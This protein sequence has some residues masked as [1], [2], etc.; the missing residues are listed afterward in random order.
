MVGS[1]LDYIFVRL[2]KTIYK[3]CNILNFVLNE[4]R[5]LFL[6]HFDFEKPE[7]FHNYDST[8]V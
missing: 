2:I 3:S 7:I 6:S 4:V 5:L 8:L 1:S